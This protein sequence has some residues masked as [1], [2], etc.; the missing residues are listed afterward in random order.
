MTA[1]AQTGAAFAGVIVRVARIDGADGLGHEA[2]HG[3]PIPARKGPGG[4]IEFAH[5]G[6][7]GRSAVHDDRK[8]RTDPR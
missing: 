3:R 1:I 6:K 2:Q 7:R 8:L 4:R 5:R